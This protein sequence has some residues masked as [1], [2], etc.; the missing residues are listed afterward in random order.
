MF[1]EKEK[2]YLKTQRLAR[3]ATVSQSLQP[4]VAPVGFDFDGQYFYVSGSNVTK[5]L[6]YRNTETNPRVALV[7][8][9][10]ETIKPWR[11][12]GIKVHGTT[13][14][15]EREGYAGRRVYL[16]IQPVRKWSWG[17][18]APLSF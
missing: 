10:L 2:A 4:D 15:V 18:E 13:D 14:R 1:T 3:I 8:D 7:A 12:R 9:D 5:T 11:P 17:V 16:R 6:K